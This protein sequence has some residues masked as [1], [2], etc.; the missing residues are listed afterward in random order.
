MTEK[1]N[2]PI[3]LVCLFVLVA[4]CVALVMTLLYFAFIER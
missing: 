3:M 2:Q 1:P 4:M